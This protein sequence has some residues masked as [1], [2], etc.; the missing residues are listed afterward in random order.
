MSEAAEQRIA[1]PVREAMQREIAL[2]SGQEVLFIADVDQDGKV[3]RAEAVARGSDVQV[4]APPQF[5]DRGALAIHNHPSGELRP[6]EA[7]LQVAGRLAELG[8]GSAIVD[9]LVERIY[10]LVEPLP[11][12]R[13]RSMLDADRLADL[14]RSDGAIAQSMD[15]FIERAG[16]V[17]MLADVARGLNDGALVLAEAGTGVGKSLAYLVPVVSWAAEND[18]RVVVS[19]AT[20]NLQQQILDK[21]LPLVQRALGTSLPV[22]LVKGRANYLCQR[23]LAEQLQEPELDTQIDTLQALSDWA[24]QSDDGSRSD[25]P[26]A[27]PEREWSS[28]ASEPDACAIARCPNRERCFVLKARRK[29]AAARVLVANHH[30]VF[31]DLAVRRSGAGWD[32]TAVLPPFRHVVFDEAHNIERSATSYF[33][34][35][36]G[37]A[38]LRK[39]ASRVSRERRS[40]RVG[41]IHRLEASGVS[42]E[43]AG[44]TARA[45]DAVREAADRM[46][47]SLAAVLAEEPS[48]RLEPASYERFRSLA[49]PALGE[50]AQ[51]ALDLAAAAARAL[52]GLDDIAREEAIAAELEAIVRRLEAAAAVVE[53]FRGP[54]LDENMVLWL[55]RGRGEV[56]LVSLVATPTDLRPI[57]R[58]SVYDPLA[59]VV[60]CSATLTVGASFAGLASRL[61][62]DMESERVRTGVYPSPF[63]YRSRVLL[64]VP[65][66]APDPGHARYDEY[67]ATLIERSVGAS[68]GGALALFTSYAQLDRIWQRVAPVLQ[69]RGHTVYRQDGSDR[70]RLLDRFKADVSSVL[71][72]TDS[73]WEGID[74][75]GATLRLVLVVRLPF[76]V[77]T[78]PIQRARGELIE[79]AGGNPFLEL[80]LPTAVTRLKQGFG[81]LMRRADDRGAVVIADPRL[82]RKFYGRVFVESLPPAQRIAASGEEIA[83][84]L[85][86][87]FA[88]D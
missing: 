57:M 26:F 81:R 31:S 76:P 35:R 70:A 18:E 60:L 47:R 88:Q 84:A 42:Q 24:E 40:R 41:L 6:S 85:R 39:H 7:D 80:S 62:I 17:A 37:L 16:Q 29:A 8:I 13:P 12:E 75:P 32:G 20:I 69:A 25:L 54:E 38:A 74:A 65:R 11:P 64:A 53:R 51:A 30:I 28:V 67:V 22:A 66:D 19:T 21:D 71:F 78:D 43:V 14:V 73:F 1:A 58:E 4:L 50:A 3:F 34:E 23:K 2:A 45:A 10:V 48:F 49:E 63:D 61:G 36:T 79:R 33:S 5:T 52:R 9:N 82:V 59:T 77:P 72:A 86:E 56:P 87:F 27:L 15:D 46:N 83:E 55:D 68:G 44:A